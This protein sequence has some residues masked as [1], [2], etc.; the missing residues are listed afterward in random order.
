MVNRY[1]GIKKKGDTKKQQ[2]G[3]SHEAVLLMKILVYYIGL[4]D[5]K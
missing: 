1:A 3:Q 4:S 5:N 2:F